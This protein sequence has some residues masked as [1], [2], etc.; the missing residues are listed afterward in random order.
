MARSYLKSNAN[1]LC[2]RIHTWETVSCLKENC[3][4]QQCKTEVLAQTG[5]MICSRQHQNS[6]T[7]CLVTTPHS[8]SS[9]HLLLLKELRNVRE[10]LC[11]GSWFSHET[12][13]K[14]VC[15]YSIL[16][17]NTSDSVQQKRREAKTKGTDCSRENELSSTAQRFA[18]KGLQVKKNRVSITRT[19]WGFGRDTRTQHKFTGLTAVSR[20][21]GEV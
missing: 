14:W 16:A 9:S 7:S 10:K 5:V 1:F 21:R 3:D 2:H 13:S 8:D 20:L 19:V 12:L 15:T 11:L 18:D 17:F 6:R 4:S